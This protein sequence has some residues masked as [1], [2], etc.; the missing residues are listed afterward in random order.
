MSKRDELTT[1]Q[2]CILWGTRV[3]IP[4]SLHK[5]V[6]EELH[7]NHP[8]IFRNKSLARAYVWWPSIDSRIE[9]TVSLC[10]T[11]QSLRSA[12]PTVQI[13]PWIFPARPWA[14][15]HEDFAGPIGGC[16]YLIVVDAYSKY[17]EVVKMPSTTSLA[18]ITALRDIFSRH[19]LPEILVSDNGSQFSSTEFERF[20][21]NNGIMHRTSAPYKPS[22]NGQAERVVQ[23]LKSEI[24]QAQATQT[25][26]SAV[27][28]KYLLVYRN[29]P[30][31]TTGEPPS[32]LLMGWRLRTRL[33]FTDSF[34]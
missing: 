6:W 7:D 22:T 16:T 9:R 2:G 28:A 11:C 12:P 13:H 10:N 19:G 18:T 25:D 3:I 32:L 30:H 27:I 20:C 31:S 33:D 34:C 26:V 1:Q 23:I 5:K 29:T 17:P 8:G 4:P 21:S 14:R 15:I 24:K